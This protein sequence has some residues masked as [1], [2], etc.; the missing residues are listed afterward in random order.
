MK[1]PESSVI[2]TG[3]VFQQTPTKT[4]ENSVGSLDGGCKVGVLGEYGGA[5]EVKLNASQVDLLRPSSGDRVTWMVE[6][7][8]YSVE[9]NAGVSFLFRELATVDQLNEL[10]KSQKVLTQ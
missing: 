5:T 9:G 3:R 4:Y 6:P 1:M 10:A 8:P 2:L 7:Y